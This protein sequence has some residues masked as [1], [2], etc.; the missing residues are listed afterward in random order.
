VSDRKEEYS[1]CFG[2]NVC[3]WGNTHFELHLFWT[4]LSIIKN[5]WD[6]SM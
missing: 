4:I 6:F 5:E 2:L 1:V 3:F